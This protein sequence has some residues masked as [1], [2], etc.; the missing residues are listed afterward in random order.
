MS[1]VDCTK[2]INSENKL[3]GR[4][5]ILQSFAKADE[6]LAISRNQIN[7]FAGASLK[8]NINLRC[9]HFIENTDQKY[10]IAAISA[11][12]VRGDHFLVGKR[13]GSHGEDTWG[14]PGGKMDFGEDWFRATQREVI[15]E[16]GLNTHEFKF[17]GLTNDYFPEDKKH[18]MNAIISCV[19]IDSTTAPRIVESNK[20]KGWDWMHYSSIEGNL[21]K[22][23]APLFLSLQNVLNTIDLK[24][25]ILARGKNESSRP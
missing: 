2:C 7:D 22:D 25:I 16:S 4:C 24:S 10:A 19:T 11:I 23:K 18:F 3:F 17:H 9:D 14:L 6:T 21:I 1:N 5:P 8:Y 12:V 13:M 20:C 15:E